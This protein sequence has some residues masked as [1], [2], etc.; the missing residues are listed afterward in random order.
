MAKEAGLKEVYLHL[1]FDGRSTEPG[2][3]PVLLETLE[4][5]MDAIGVGQIVTGGG[6]GIALDRDGNYAKT[7]RA[8]EAM[9]LGYGK[10]LRRCWTGLEMIADKDSTPWTIWK[11]SH[12][13]DA[14]SETLYEKMKSIHAGIAELELYE[15]RYGLNDLIPQRVGNPS[16]WTA[17][18]KSSNR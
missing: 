2:S 6:R 15:F 3:A 13:P 8:Y 14:F 9:V 7:R 11:P 18:K 17:R 1:I 5:Q 4:E 12:N 10:P 16:Y